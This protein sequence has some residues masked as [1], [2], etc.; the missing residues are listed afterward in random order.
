MGFHLHCRKTY[1]YKAPHGTGLWKHEDVQTGIC[2]R[3]W[4]FRP[5]IEQAWKPIG[6]T[7]VLQVKSMALQGMK[8]LLVRVWWQASMRIW[9]SMTE[10]LL[11]WKILKL[12]L[13]LMM[14]WSIKVPKALPNVYIKGWIPNFIETRQCGYKAYSS[15]AMQLGMNGMEAKNGARNA[16]NAHSE[17]IR[18][19]LKNTSIAPWS[20]KWLFDIDWIFAHWPEG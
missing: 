17:Q 8:R 20:D 16:K 6:K 2:H 1:S 19:F 15:C 5:P 18:R 9:P 4:L 10:S 12:T 13:V 7:F 11:S 3:V 14:I